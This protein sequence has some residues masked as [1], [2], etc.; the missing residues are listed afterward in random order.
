[1]RNSSTLTTN[2]TDL[3]VFTSSYLRLDI[4]KHAVEYYFIFKFKDV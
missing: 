1:M 3:P 2:T 4:S